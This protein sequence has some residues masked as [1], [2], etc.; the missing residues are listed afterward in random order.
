MSKLA[1]RIRQTTRPEVAPFGFAAAAARKP[2]AQ[3][4]CLVSLAGSEAEGVA[5]ASQKGADGVI[6][7]GVD[8]DKLKEVVATNKVSAGVR[9]AT[10]QRSDLATQKEAGADFA[11]LSL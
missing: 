5:G 10:G 4:I 1:D 7:R 3:M 2:S 6:L 11:V 8:P 9:L